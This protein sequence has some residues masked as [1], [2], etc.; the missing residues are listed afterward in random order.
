[1]YYIIS[2]IS[3]NQAILKNLN[4]EKFYQKVLLINDLKENS[5]DNQLLQEKIQN[6][7][8]NGIILITDNI[9]NNLSLIVFLMDIDQN[10]VIF[11]PNQKEYLNNQKYQEKLGIKI[12]NSINEIENKLKS[13][14]IKNTI[15]HLNKNIED[16]I[17]KISEELSLNNNVKRYVSMQIINENP[18]Y[19]KFLKQTKIKIIKEHLDYILNNNTKKIIDQTIDLLK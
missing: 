15:P 16:A 4:Q 3:D 7:E 10:M 9:N 6:E 2:T 14:S 18:F 5:S 13:K 8:I 12:V 1:M 19:Q 11:I 17:S